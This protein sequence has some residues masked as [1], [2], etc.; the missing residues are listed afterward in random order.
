MAR[1]GL[2]AKLYFKVNGVTSPGPWIELTNVRDL[3]LSLETG[4]ADVTTRATQGW[5]ATIGTLREASIEW[6]MIW[7]GSGDA[8]FTAIKDAF[9]Q[10]KLIGLAVMDGDIATPGN[11]GLQSDCSVTQFTREE[12]LSEALTAKIT[13][14]PSLS[15]VAPAWVTVP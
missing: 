6:E 5:K 1:L 11:Q 8:G 9:F 10:G 7:A 13:A 3:T 14:K 2:A 12:P 4:E 15:T